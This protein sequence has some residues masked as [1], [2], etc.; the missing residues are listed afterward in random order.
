MSTK[1]E[2]EAGY[3]KQELYSRLHSINVVCGRHL[4]QQNSII[5][6]SLSP[7]PQLIHSP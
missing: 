5:V 2:A 3:F 4:S 7:R 1:A 6:T